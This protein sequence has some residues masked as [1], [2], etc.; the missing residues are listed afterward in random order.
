MSVREVW[1]M[2]MTV[3]RGVFGELDYGQKANESRLNSGINSN[4]GRRASL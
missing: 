1:N 2:R 3:S 4:L